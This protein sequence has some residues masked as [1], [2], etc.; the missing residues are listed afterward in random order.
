MRLAFAVAAHLE[1]EILIID[2][3]LAVGDAAFQKK[4]LAKMGEV[5]KAGRTVLFV[6]HNMMAVQ[7]LCDQVIWLEGGQIAQI[8]APEQVVAC[9]LQTSFSSVTEQVWDERSTAPGNDKVRLRRACVRPIGG[10]PDDPITTRTPFVI[11]FEYW[12]LQPGAHLNL[13][14]QLHNKDWVMVFDTAP[15]YELLWQERPLPVGL[16]RDTC[17]IPGDLLNNGTYSVKVFVIKD[18]RTRIYTHGE[19]LVF[20]VHD[21]VE[22]RGHWYGQ[23]QGVIRP[24][25]EWN[26]ELIEADIEANAVDVARTY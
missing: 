6:S 24:A 14:F 5:A 26:T 3:V 4:C 23:W 21:T 2:E 10:S 1:P 8:G 16:F 15:A 19:I 22:M 9:Y 18:Q 25:L 7:S 17:H 11:E 13:R 12:N 20:D